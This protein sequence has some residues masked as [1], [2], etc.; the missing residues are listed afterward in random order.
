MEFIFILELTVFKFCTQTF[1][2]YFF[3]MQYDRSVYAFR[4]VTNL[5]GVVEKLST[6]TKVVLCVHGFEGTHE[7]ISYFSRGVVFD[8][9][10]TKYL[11]LKGNSI[12]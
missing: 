6:S 1:L 9:R 7:N 2:F 10:V 5:R 8:N 4:V 11:F 12:M 3:Y